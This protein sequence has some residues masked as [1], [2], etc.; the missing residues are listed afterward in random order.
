MIP[1][2]P[3]DLFTMF[4]WFKRRRKPQTEKRSLEELRQRLNTIEGPRLA[5]LKGG[6]G[7]RRAPRAMKSCG[8]WLPQ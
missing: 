2:G 3:Q 8:G 6:R 7:M 4:S 1:H 5:E